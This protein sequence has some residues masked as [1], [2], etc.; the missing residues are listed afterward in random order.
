MVNKDEYIKLKF[1]M[2]CPKKNGNLMTIDY[3][4]LGRFLAISR[5]DRSVLADFLG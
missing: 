3:D 2:L 5:T 4:Y 1:P